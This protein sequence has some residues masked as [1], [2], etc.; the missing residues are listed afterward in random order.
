MSFVKTLRQFYTT[1]HSLAAPIIPYVS[2]LRTKAGALS[3][4]LLTYICKS[5]TFEQLQEFTVSHAV[6]S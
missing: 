4:W 2:M 5:A 6:C 1:V 3:V